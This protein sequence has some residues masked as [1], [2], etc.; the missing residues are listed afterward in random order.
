[1]ESTSFSA[2]LNKTTNDDGDNDNDDGDDEN[3]VFFNLS[4]DKLIITLSE[5]YLVKF[6]D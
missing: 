3:K 6:R 4:R 2:Q 1:M 5:R